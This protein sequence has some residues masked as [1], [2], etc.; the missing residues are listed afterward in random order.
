MQIAI[1]LGFTAIYF[2]VFR[3]LIL[4]FDLPTPGRTDDGGEDKLF[5]KAEYKA[6]KEMEKKG[7]A[8]GA[9]ALKAQVFLDCLG[10]PDNIREVTNCATRLRVTVND[11]DKVAATSKFTKPVPSASS[12]TATPSRS[13]SACP[14]PMSA[15]TSTP[16]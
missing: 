1:G 14:C 11:P 2:V 15:A 13:S 16:S 8:G 9:D 7:I 6:K 12:R 4:H 3:F 5:T 10:G